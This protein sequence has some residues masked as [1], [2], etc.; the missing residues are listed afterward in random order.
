M[1]APLE[2]CI[3]CEKIHRGLCAEDKPKTAPKKRA[4]K[5]LPAQEPAPWEPPVNGV[6]DRWAGVAAS[7][8]TEEQTALQTLAGIMH[9]EELEKHGLRRPTR[10]QLTARTKA[11]KEKTWLVRTPRPPRA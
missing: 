2:E 8:F 4:V 10:P 1:P 5:T 11:W 3:F 7:Q 6:L 9:P